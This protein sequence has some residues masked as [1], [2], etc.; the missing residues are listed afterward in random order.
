MTVLILLPALFVL[1]FGIWIFA[2][3]S[4]GDTAFWQKL[5]YVTLAAIA[6]L[7]IFGITTLAWNAT[8]CVGGKSF[9]GCTTTSET[10]GQRLYIAIW[11]S[12][13]SALPA[14]IAGIGV[15]A[16]AGGVKVFNLYHNN[17]T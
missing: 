4:M 5:I 1:G 11:L 12:T 10:Y 17:R 3:P 16:A 9:D 14:L 8:D 7:V 13:L 15:M 2:A 6:P